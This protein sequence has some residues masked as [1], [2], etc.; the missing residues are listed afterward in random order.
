M[1]KP[2]RG[3]VRGTTGGPATQSVKEIIMK[4]TIRRAVVILLTSAGLIAV[5]EAA[6]QAKLTA[7]CH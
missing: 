7:N 2:G 3:V 5:T 4:R 6:A 1:L